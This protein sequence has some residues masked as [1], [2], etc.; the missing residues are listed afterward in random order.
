[1]KKCN[2]CGY[3]ETDDAQ[4]CSNCGHN[5]FT[6]VNK[7]AQNPYGQQGR[8]GG[9]PYGNM[10][11]Q[12]QP[13]LNRPIGWLIL[14]IFLPFISGYKLIRPDVSS[15][16]RT[17]GIVWSIISVV[18]YF[19]NAYMFYMSYNNPSAVV[20]LICGILTVIPL[21][22]YASNSKKYKEEMDRKAQEKLTEDLLNQPLKTFADEEVEKIAERY[23]D[24]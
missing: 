1:M 13:E 8:P 18:A 21:I 23:K 19:F 11:P 2:I 24:A 9:A 5:E 14:H 17:F 20:S 4:F 7:A 22:L 10:V 15:G 3:A 6:A 12:A 16:F